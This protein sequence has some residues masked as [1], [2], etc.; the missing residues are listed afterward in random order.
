MPAL[1]GYN[2]PM[3]PQRALAVT[4]GPSALAR[5]GFALA[6]AAAGTAIIT[7]PDGSSVTIPLP[8]GQQVFIEHTH[9]TGGTATGIVSYS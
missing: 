7:T 6:A 5:R 1:P 4:P 8:V 9:V 2:G 3:I